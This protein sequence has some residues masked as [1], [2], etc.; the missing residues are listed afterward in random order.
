ME[1]LLYLDLF[2]S[3]SDRVDDEGVSR[4]PGSLRSC[5]DPRLQFILNANGGRGHL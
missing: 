3:L 2:D 1:L 4:F 5:S